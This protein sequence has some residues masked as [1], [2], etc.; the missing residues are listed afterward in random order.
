[1]YGSFFIYYSTVVAIHEQS[2]VRFAHIKRTKWAWEVLSGVI[3][4]GVTMIFELL[5]T[6][7]PISWEN[8]HNSGLE[9]S[10]FLLLNF[11]GKVWFVILLLLKRWLRPSI[12]KSSYKIVRK[13]M[14][15]NH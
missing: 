14:L 10:P 7:T 4:R 13:W 5:V 11:K 2:E 3:P 6:K 12:F 1:M 9:S 15:I 8:G